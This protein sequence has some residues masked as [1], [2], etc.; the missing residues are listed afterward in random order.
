MRFLN[1]KYFLIIV[2][3][4]GLVFGIFLE[5]QYIFPLPQ[6]D[7]IINKISN[8]ISQTR[9]GSWFKPNHNIYGKHLTKELEDDIRKLHSIG[10]MAGSKPVPDQK[11]VTVFDKDHAFNG[12]N[13]VVSGHK[14]E[15]VLMDMKGNEIHKWH[16]SASKAF[17]GKFKNHVPNYLTF[18]RRAHLAENGDLFAVFEGYG[19]VKLDKNSNIIWSVQNR[20]HHDIYLSKNG[21][22]YALTRK[23]TIVPQYNRKKP[24][25]EDFISILNE[26]GEELDRISIL[27]ALKNSS[28]AH[29]FS[30]MK[31]WGD[32]L[33][34]NTIELI[35]ELPSGKKPPFKKGVILISILYLDM[36]CAVDITKKTVI[37]AE[38][39]L[40]RDQHQPTLLNNGNILFFNN[41]EAWDRSS[42]IEF[43]P[44]SRDITW[45]YHGSKDKPFYTPFNGSC[46]RLPNGNTLIT[47]SDPGRAFEVTP[48][49]RIV[50]EYI[51]PHRA[52]EQREFIATLFEVVRIKKDFTKKWLD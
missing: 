17:P 7:R 40:G 34:T 29:V 36:I 6:I 2:F 44:F 38:F 51:N 3:I 39:N 24:I 8:R 46:Q 11:D 5:R 10:Y 16:C 45:A 23:A 43:D 48:E 18:W 37:W 27:K 4:T 25:L 13:L 28:Y 32:I 41:K 30:K 52:G 49:N 26:K 22:I 33:H 31:P 20:A 42:V 35:E 15:A 9:S 19:L 50:W 47:E 21:L 14:P 1:L 12:Y